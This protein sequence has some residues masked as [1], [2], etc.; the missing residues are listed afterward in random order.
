MVTDGSV[1]NWLQALKDGNDDAAQ[2][3][4][5]RYFTQLVNLARHRLG[6]FPRRV[7]DEDDVANSAFAS[8]CQRA[9]E[10]R[11]PRLNDRDDLWRLL[12]VITARKAVDLVQRESRQKRGGGRLPGFELS[13][14]QARQLAIG[15]EPTPEF[16]A[17]FAEEFRRLLGRLGED[18]L[19]RAALLK[20]EGHSNAEIAEE[21]DCSL[22]SVERKLQVIRSIWEGES[23]YDS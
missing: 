14:E 16:A 8:F 10:G 1:T 18:S 12:A 2:Q 19:R 3:L 6:D 21:L 7:A 5:E 4:W 23:P 13:D 20:F 11:F 9:K 15:N 22:R 17:Q